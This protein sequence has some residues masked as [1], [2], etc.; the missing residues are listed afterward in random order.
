MANISDPGGGKEPSGVNY[1]FQSFCI[2]LPLDPSGRGSVPIGRQ[3]H[4]GEWLSGY[5]S[6]QL[7][8]RQVENRVEISGLLTER[9]IDLTSPVST[10][11]V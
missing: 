10:P 1:L 9:V 3:S 4:R 5:L 11:Q 7:H 2:R 8:L 6:L